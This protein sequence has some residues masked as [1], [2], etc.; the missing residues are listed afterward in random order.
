M[1]KFFNDH[2]AMINVYLW[3]LLAVSYTITQQSAPW[4]LY[5]IACSVLAINFLT[6][7]NY[8]KLQKLH[9]E[10]HSGN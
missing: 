7:H 5:V 10:H 1:I 9:N 2:G 6:I 3:S 8:E 4:W